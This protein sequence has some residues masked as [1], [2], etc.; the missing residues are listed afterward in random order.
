MR[1]LASP[2]ARSPHIDIL[3]G[4]ANFKVFADMVKNVSGEFSRRPP[5]FGST[6]INYTYRSPVGVIGDLPLNL[7]L[8]LMT[9]KVGSA[10]ACGNTVVVKPSEETPA[11]PHCS[12]ADEQSRDPWRGSTTW[13][14][15]STELCG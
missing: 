8:L 6:A 12:A 14:T 9:L 13:C 4:A 3:R 15:A 10:L 5:R 7:P 2:A 1:G 11:P